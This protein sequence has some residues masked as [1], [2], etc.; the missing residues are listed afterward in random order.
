MPLNQSTFSTLLQGA[1]LI[2]I[3]RGMAPQETAR[4]AS[5]LWESGVRLVEIPL[6]SPTSHDAFRETLLAKADY[7]EATLGMGS[8]RTTDDYR[9]AQDVGADFTVSPGLFP[10]ICR[11][12]L[13]DKMAHLPGVFSPTE[14]GHAMEL[15]FAEV[16]LFPASV[17][18]PAGL[19]K[20]LDPFPTA[21]IVAVGGVDKTNC[22]Q[23]ISQGAFAVGM[24]TSL[25]PLF[26]SMSDFLGSLSQPQPK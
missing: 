16:K 11:E 19:A 3:L 18:G 24:G 23:F 14:V 6:H 22:H 15:G 20:I 17:Y 1:P 21:R 10:K 25:A 8:I 9:F 5:L 7:T 26:G 13:S 2:A 12:S 4:A